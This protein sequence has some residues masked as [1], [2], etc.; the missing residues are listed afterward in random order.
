MSKGKI[1][2]LKEATVAIIMT[3]TQ[4]GFFILLERS[5]S[6]LSQGELTNSKEVILVILLLV[7]SAVAFSLSALLVRSIYITGA[8]LIGGITLTFIILP[9]FL[10]LIPGYILGVSLASAALVQIKREVSR[11][12]GFYLSHLLKSGLPLYLTAISVIAATNYAAYISKEKPL[13]TMLPRSALNYVLNWVSGE[14]QQGGL[15]FGAFDPNKTLE[16]ALYELSQEEITATIRDE[17]G[18]NSIE[19]T[20]YKEQ[21]EKMVAERKASLSKEIGVALSGKEKIADVV[22][23]LASKKLEQILGSYAQYLPFVS[24]IAFFLAFKA[25]TFPLYYMTILIVFLLV[26]LMLLLN[27]LVK[28]SKTITVNTVSLAD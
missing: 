17:L 15:G 12:T 26:R 7:I 1:I 25:L 6:L 9:N 28:R 19:A 23:L 8:G 14:K 5:I 3:A 21:I 11:S 18:T 20:I 2:N 10:R 16:Q 27:I 13:G 22:R 4:I 24:V